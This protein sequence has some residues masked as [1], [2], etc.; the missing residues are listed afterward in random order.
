M[1]CGKRMLLFSFDDVC[2]TLIGGEAVDEFR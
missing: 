2:A 1:K